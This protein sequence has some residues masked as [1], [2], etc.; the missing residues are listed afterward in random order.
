[1]VIKRQKLAEMIA[2]E[3]RRRL[4]ELADD[5]GRPRPRKPATASADQEDPPRG[6]GPGGPDAALGSPDASRPEGGEGSEDD[7]A[8]PAVDG[9]QPDPEAIDPDGTGGEEGSGAVNDYLSGKT[10]QAISI[11][12]ES[13][14]L[15]GAK[16]V[17][18][19]FN[20]TTDAL[21]ILVTTTGQ[22]KF[23]LRGQ[24]HDIP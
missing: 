24:L 13:K 8:G 23:F 5:D 16:E 6:P 11:E 10:V 22:V 14:V 4:R 7:P 19:S 15:P 21:R 2:E 12:P 17:I 1:M 18:V 3:V 9:D 20:E